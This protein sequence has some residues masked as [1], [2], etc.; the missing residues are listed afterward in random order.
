MG[1][2]L[3]DKVVI[4]TGG[5]SETGRAI[6]TGFAG[7]GAR[8]V[9][10]DIN[11]AGAQETAAAATKAGQKALAVEVDVSVQ[12]QVESMVEAAVAAFGRV[13]VLVHAA[14][15]FLSVPM[16]ECTLEQWNR[17]QDVNIRGTM[18]CTQ[19]VCRVMKEQNYGKIVLVSSTAGFRGRVGQ[20]A[21][22][23]SR[24]A[25]LAFTKS[26]GLQMGRYGI[27]INTLA[28]GY[29]DTDSC[30]SLKDEP[31]L[32]KERIA[33]NPMRRLG[34]PEDM[35]GPA[36]FLASDDSKY[37]TGTTLAVDGGIAAFVSG[38]DF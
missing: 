19:A 11:I 38:V 8:I 4:I 33:N 1:M 25:L 12:A 29:L 16:L 28:A 20:Q 37:V 6:A 15:V 14:S 36:L 32:R 26:V 35:V 23:A 31:E 27:T 18:L 3:K 34:E 24:G 21:Y 30:E 7:E 5:A 2:R 10:A 13:D 22:C 9:V 17:V